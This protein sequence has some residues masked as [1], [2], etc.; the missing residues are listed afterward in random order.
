MFVLKCKYKTHDKPFDIV[1]IEN[2]GLQCGSNIYIF[3][4]K[5]IIYLH[6]IFRWKNKTKS[7]LALVFKIYHN[8]K[9]GVYKENSSV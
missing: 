3:E 2:D 5:I 1:Y 7:I 9:K 8:Y 4:T 6:L